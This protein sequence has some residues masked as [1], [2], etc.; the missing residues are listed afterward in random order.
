MIESESL[1]VSTPWP[2]AAWSMVVLSLIAGTVGVAGGILSPSLVLDLVATWPLGVP[3]IAA[4]APAVVLRTRRPRLL[5]APPL[6]VLTWMFAVAGL[7]LA[8]WSTLPSAAADLLGPPVE[9]INRAEFS[10]VTDAGRIVAGSAAGP[11]LFEVVPTRRGGEAGV[12]AVGVDRRGTEASVR[13]ESRES[14]GWYRFSGW[15]VGL[16]PQP[17]WTV[18]VAAPE[19]ILD[20]TGLRIDRLDLIGSGRLVVSG[21]PAEVSVVGDFRIAVPPDLPVRV[22]GPARVPDDWSAT[23]DGYRSPGEGEEW[24]ITVVD[25]ADVLIQEG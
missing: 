5:A 3:A 25:D 6:L 23:D 14:S 17:V 21:P 18:T 7:H 10:L 15:S 2:V 22:V 12:P 19:V 1:G 4:A 8:G 9:G 13:V 16:A 11:H 20:L 24:V